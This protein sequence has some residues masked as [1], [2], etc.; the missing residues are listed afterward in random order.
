MNPGIN[1]VIVAIEGSYDDLR[2][3][4]MMDI[5]SGSATAPDLVIGYP[6]HFAEYEGGEHW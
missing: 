5:N 3:N 4:T 6:D 2:A 1:V